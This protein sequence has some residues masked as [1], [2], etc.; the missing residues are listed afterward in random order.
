[1]DFGNGKTMVRLLLENTIKSTEKKYEDCFFQVKVKVNANTLESYH[2]RIKSIIDEDLSIVELQY[3]KQKS[4]GKG[5]NCA[6]CWDIDN[7]QPQW[8]ETT[9]MPE[10]DINNFSNDVHRS[11]KGKNFEDVLELYKLSVWGLNDKELIHK[12][13]EFAT[14]YETWIET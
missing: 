5:V 9:F 13:N 8:I 6:V 3:E 10:V 14:S 11:I 1:M 4:Y 2:E 7:N 12:L